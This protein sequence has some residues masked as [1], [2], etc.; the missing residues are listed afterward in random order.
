[1]DATT[2]SSFAAAALAAATIGVRAVLYLRMTGAMERQ[3]ER[4]MNATPAQLEML[5]ACQLPEP[6]R[7]TR[8]FLVLLLVAAAA[9]GVAAAVVGYEASK[10]AAYNK[11]SECSADQPC[12]NGKCQASTAQPIAEI[13]WALRVLPKDY[14]YSLEASDAPK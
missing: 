6:S 9:N 11:C 14:D 5:K 10:Y 8:L 13:I 2:A 3:Q 1:M 7:I 12:V 4:I